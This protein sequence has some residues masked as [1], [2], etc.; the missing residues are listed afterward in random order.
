M[1]T[2]KFSLIESITNTLVGL[3]VSFLVQII[4][5]PLMSITVRFEQNIVITLIFTIVSILRSYIL[6]RIFNKI[7][8]K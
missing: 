8:N 5:Y 4:I 6:R 2:K 7:R 3:I 1:Q